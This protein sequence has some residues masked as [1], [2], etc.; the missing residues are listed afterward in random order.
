MKQERRQE[1]ISE[2]NPRDS[3]S[4][5]NRAEKAPILKEALALREGCI[6]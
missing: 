3:R 2:N 6:V 1:L 5:N 4:G